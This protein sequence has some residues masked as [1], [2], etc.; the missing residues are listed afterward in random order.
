MLP[1]GRPLSVFMAPFRR[2]ISAHSSCEILLMARRCLPSERLPMNLSVR[3]EEVRV[4]AAH[5]ENRPG[6]AKARRV[7]RQIVV[8]G[9]CGRPATWLRIE[10]RRNALAV[11]PADHR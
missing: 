11:E 4:A 2:R 7:E 3:D 9:A 8:A 6:V 1:N 10:V 5:E